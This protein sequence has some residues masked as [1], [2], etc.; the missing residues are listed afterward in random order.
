MVF[1]LP[2]QYSALVILL[3]FKAET[4]HC[5]SFSDRKWLIFWSTFGTRKVCTIEDHMLI[6]IY[7]LLYSFPKWKEKKKRKLTTF[8]SF[9]SFKFYV[10]SDNFCFL[11]HL[12]IYLSIL[13]W[14]WNI[15]SSQN[16][17]V[18]EGIMNSELDFLPLLLWW[19]CFVSYILCLKFFVF[20]SGLTKILKSWSWK[21]FAYFFFFK[22]I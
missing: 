15:S 1:L 18:Y 21:K 8:F 17:L 16:T 20:I 4:V 3:H 19:V 7:S 10:N 14:R 2:F 22:M 6:W 11:L 5:G 12:S 13:F 9:F